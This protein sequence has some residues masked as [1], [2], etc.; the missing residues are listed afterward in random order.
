MPGSRLSR[1]SESASTLVLDLPA[2]R[3]VSD[4]YLLLKPPNLWHFV[5]AAQTEE[6]RQEVVSVLFYLHLWKGIVE[7]KDFCLVLFGLASVEENVMSVIFTKPRRHCAWI[8]DEAA[9]W[10]ACLI[11]MH[12]QTGDEISMVSL[13]F[14]LCPE[15]HMA[16]TL[17]RES[18][19]GNSSREVL[20]L[21]VLEWIIP[22]ASEKPHN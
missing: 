13:P 21:W 5:R 4:K 12:R 10:N 1:D 15:P 8:S 9:I 14:P 6:D 22:L 18:S 20:H 19:G 3:I 2:S 17:S 11:F 16:S 7:W